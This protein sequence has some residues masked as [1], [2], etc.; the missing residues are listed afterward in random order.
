MREDDLLTAVLDLCALLHLR[1][2]H[3][4]PART[5]RGFRTAVQGDGIGWPD[6]VIVGPHRVLYRELKSARGTVSAQQRAWLH[7]L[8]AAGQDA[9]VW[10]TQD[11]MSGRIE[12]ELAALRRMVVAS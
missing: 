4:R 10:A 3:F 2:A 8:T 5:A 7:A 1:T 9:A 11:L 12:H 6:L